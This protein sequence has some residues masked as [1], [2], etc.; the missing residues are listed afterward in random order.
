[1]MPHSYSPFIYVGMS[2]NPDLGY[3]CK[4]TGGS[5]S[6]NQQVFVHITNITQLF[7]PGIL[8]PGEVQ[9]WRNKGR[10]NQDGNAVAA[11]CVDPRLERK[12]FWMSRLR[13]T[14]TVARGLQTGIAGAAAHPGWHSCEGMLDWKIR[15]Y[16]RS[17]LMSSCVRPSTLQLHK[18]WRRGVNRAV[19]EEDHEPDSTIQSWK[20]WAHCDENQ[21]HTKIRNLCWVKPHI[22][23]MQLVAPSCCCSVY[24]LFDVNS[25]QL[26]VAAHKW[27][28]IGWQV[29][30]KAIP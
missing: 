19:W 22:W 12:R 2:S 8:C 9:D 25:L 7:T 3:K 21:I 5:Q 4:G 29:V 13:C 6:I 27:P 30:R 24:H 28:F 10:M 15:D 14:D 23:T 16:Y 17:G 20:H 11:L 18:C 26:E 1:M